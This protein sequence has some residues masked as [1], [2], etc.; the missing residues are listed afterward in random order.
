MEPDENV[1]DALLTLLEGRGWA[2]AI[3]KDVNN[4]KMT[5]QSSDIKAV[6]SEATLPACQAKDVLR[7]CA[8]QQ[9]PVIFTGHDLPAQAAVDLIRQ[10]GHDYLEKPFQQER[11]LDLLKHLP[12]R[13]NR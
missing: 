12:N 4:L 11:L 3:V 9:V 5:L 1:C 2:V 6:I 13:H 8:Q 7:V 10:G